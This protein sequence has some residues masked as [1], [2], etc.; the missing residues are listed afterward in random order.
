MKCNSKSEYLFS[1]LCLKSSDKS[2]LYLFQ[3]LSGSD[4]W[5]KDIKIA[6]KFRT[7]DDFFVR[8]A[9]DPMYHPNVYHYLEDLKLNMRTEKSNNIV[10]LPFLVG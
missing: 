9:S 3:R 5:Q 4:N 6:N 8:T 10:H 1:N 2:F 7:C